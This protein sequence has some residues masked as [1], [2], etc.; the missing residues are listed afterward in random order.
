MFLKQIQ[1]MQK[2]LQ[3][4]EWPMG[5]LSHKN[6]LSTRPHEFWRIF[7][8]NQFYL[9]ILKNYAFKLYPFLME[10]Y[11]V[12]KRSLEAFSGHYVWPCRDW[13][14]SQKSEFSLKEIIE[15]NLKIK[16]LNG[17]EKY[18]KLFLDSKYGKIS[19]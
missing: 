19:S 8:R 15:H 2:R 11:R 16:K 7:R 17:Q 9:S 12:D 5:S 1:R 10:C 18:F 6:L 13:N 14:T 3:Y 4:W